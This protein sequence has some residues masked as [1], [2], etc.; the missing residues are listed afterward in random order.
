[1]QPT[2]PLLILIVAVFAFMIW[3][4]TRK[5]KTNTEQLEKVIGLL[6]EIDFNLN[7]IETRKANFHSKK[8]F[9]VYCWRLYQGKL[10]F[11]SEDI[12]AGLRDGFTIAEDCNTKIA[13]ALKSKD[14]GPLQTLEMEKM[15]EPFALARTGL[16]E[17]LKVDYEQK[18]AAK[19]RGRPGR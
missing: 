9:R 12:V 17:W 13:A 4:S 1:M 6:Q 7:N 10:E 18:N 16:I 11:V 19:G 2:I 14:L 5:P 15:R 8:L 3:S